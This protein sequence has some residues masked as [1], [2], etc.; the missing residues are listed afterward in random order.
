MAAPSSRR[1]PGWSAVPPQVEPRGTRPIEWVIAVAGGLAL[2]A[3]LVWFLR[4]P[5]PTPDPVEPAPVAPMIAPAVAPPVAAPKRP[6]SPPLAADTGGYK[7]RGLIVRPDGS[8]SAIIETADGRQRLVRPGS[9]VGAGVTV[10]MIDAA[11]V[12]LAGSGSRQLLALVDGGAASKADTDRAEPGR[13]AAAPTSAK[14][15]ARPGELVASAND[16]R[17]A[18]KPRRIGSDIT[19]YTLIDASRLPALRLAGLRAGD[20]LISVNGTGIESEEKLIE[21]PQEIAGAY[22]VDVVFERDGKRQQAQV[23]IK[24]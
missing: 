23:A 1:L 9:S 11:G 2:S 3:V 4:G 6:A 7:L 14:P 21:L 19:G 13:I 22:A 8:G 10:E 18:L 17:L 12:T 16:Y 20:V 5:A 24:R 15:A